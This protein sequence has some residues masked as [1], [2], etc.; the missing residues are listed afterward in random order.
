MSVGRV[1]RAAICSG[2]VH[3]ARRSTMSRKVLSIAFAD[4][5]RVV[6]N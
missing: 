6:E 1:K 2:G 3:L 5:A 4:A